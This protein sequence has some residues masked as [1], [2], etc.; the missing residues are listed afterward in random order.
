MGDVDGV[1]HAT[2]AS[3][4]GKFT[5]SCMQALARIIRTT[6]ADI[7]LSSSWRTS[8]GAIAEVNKALSTHG[9]KA[10]IGCTP[11]LAVAREQ[12]V[13]RWLDEHH[14]EVARW[15]AIDDIDLA[16]NHVICECSKR[17]QGHFV[18]TNPNTGLTEAD[19]GK[20]IALI[21]NQ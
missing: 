6:G 13:C 17:M 12:E 20:A 8:E 21:A 1:L 3:V 4:K 15:I 9:L 7:V 18:H 19:A 16:R 5:P 14:G 10:V 2:S 11:I